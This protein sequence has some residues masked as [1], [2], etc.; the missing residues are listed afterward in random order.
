LK[1]LEQVGVS[2]K[3]DGTLAFDRQKF[4]EK[5][6]ADSASVKKFFSDKDQGVVKKLE[7][8]IDTIAGR[9]SSLLI[10]RAGA[11]QNKIESNNERINS[12]NVRLVR[13][14]DRL[15]NQF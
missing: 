9:D 1:S 11:L 15:L 10:S 4:S 7:D 2:A 12:H 14:R 5:F 13:E 6:A 8:L 3:N